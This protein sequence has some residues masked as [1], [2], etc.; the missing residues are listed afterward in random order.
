M[1]EWGNCIRCGLEDKEGTFQELMGEPTVANPDGGTGDPICP[2][3]IERDEYA[4]RQAN[5][6]CTCDLLSP[7]G[8]VTCASCNGWGPSDG[9]EDEELMAELGIT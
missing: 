7:F 6:E 1:S 9:S 8:H 3:C 2:E 4:K 5:G